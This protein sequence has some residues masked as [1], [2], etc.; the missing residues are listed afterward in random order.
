M[1][2]SYY[3]GDT[4][5]VTPTDVKDYYYCK[6]IP[7]L[8]RVTG[9]VEPA[10]PSMDSGII[11]ATRKEE[12]ASKLNLPRPYRVEVRLIDRELGVSGVIDVV[13]G[14]NKIHILEIK[15]GVRKPSRRHIEQ[16]KVY[17]LLA[18]RTIGRVDEAILYWKNGVKRIKIT[19][20]LLE[21]AQRSI[22]KVKQ[23]L[24]TEDPPTVQQPKPKCSYCWFNKLCPLRSI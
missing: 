13:A 1:R 15:A 22:H 20:K 11:D 7:W 24:E 14:A 16:L 3:Y 2:A 19:G 18:A 17:A 8:R 9:R 6:A 21:D 4:H 5:L 10:T 12:I 23:L